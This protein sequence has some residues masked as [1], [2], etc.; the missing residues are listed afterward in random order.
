MTVDRIIGRFIGL[1]FLAAVFAFLLIPLAYVAFGSLNETTLAFPPR[2]LSARS[3]RTIPEAFFRALGVS[4][5]VAA[6]STCIAIPLGVGGAFSLVRGRFPGRDLVNGILLSPLL[7][8]MLVLGVGLYQF[9]HGVG[10]A[11]GIPLT[12]SLAGLILGHVSFCV[13]YVARAV[14]PVLASL[15]PSLEE[16]AQDLGAG[17]WI[18]FSW[19]TLPLIRTGLLAGAA[20]AFLT[21]FDNFPM[22]LFLAEGENATLPVVVF[23]FIEFDL[24][25]TVLAMSTLVILFSLV[26]MVIV[27]R[28]IGLATFV[29]LRER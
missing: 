22:S 27:E 5:I 18:T 8:P 15:P 10:Q 2:T 24:K 21:S 9:Y 7:L 20:F 28:T 12:G 16:A 14:M 26:A 3:Y 25:P 11:T 13:P 4:L 23:H 6:T 17:R 29:G 1:A 19:V